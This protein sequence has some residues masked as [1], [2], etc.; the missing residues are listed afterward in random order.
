MSLNEREVNKYLQ[1]FFGQHEDGFQQAWLEI[2]ERSPQTLEEVAPIVRKI[3]NRAIKQYLNKKYKEDSLYK[4]IGKNGDEKFTLESVLAN[5]EDE[6][7]E[8][9]SG[10]DGLYKKIVDFLIREYLIQKNENFALKRK[11]IDLKAERLRLRG[12]LLQFKKYRFRSWKK[13]MEDKGKQK[14][15]QLKLK[16][17]LEREK[18]K[19]K[20]EQLSLKLTYL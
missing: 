6:V 16:V 2:L 1:P 20:K 12:E 13:L 18:N 8:E 17:Q 4:P 11:E 10:R 3:R 5:P 15:K 7:C 9:D 19:F 14:E